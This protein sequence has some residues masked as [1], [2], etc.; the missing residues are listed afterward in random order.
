MKNLIDGDFASNNGGWQWFDSNG[1]YIRRWLPELKD[2]DS[3]VIHDP[4]KFS[5]KKEFEKLG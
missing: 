3:K 1:D 4:F 5:S 2:L